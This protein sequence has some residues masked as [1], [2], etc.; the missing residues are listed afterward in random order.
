VSLGSA[1]ADWTKWGQKYLGMGRRSICV[2]FRRQYSIMAT[3]RA[4][5]L[6]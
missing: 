1:F 3:Y 6:C 4:F 5:I 2:E